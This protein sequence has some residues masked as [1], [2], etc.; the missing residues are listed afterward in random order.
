M[1]LSSDIHHPNELK[2]AFPNAIE[3]L[4]DAGIGKVYEFGGSE[5]ARVLH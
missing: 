3:I 1:M 2:G 5:L 4:K